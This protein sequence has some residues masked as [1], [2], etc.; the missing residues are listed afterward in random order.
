M[1]SGSEW[2]GPVEVSGHVEVSE[3]VE[4]SG[5]VEVSGQVEVEASEWAGCTST[6]TRY[7]YLVLMFKV[8]L[9]TGHHKAMITSV[10]SYPGLVLQP[11]G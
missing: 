1:A 2:T 11:L 5:H 4:V 6:G 10:Q 7:R 9:T 8:T 3:Q